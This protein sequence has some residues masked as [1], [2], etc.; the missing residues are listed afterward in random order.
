MEITKRKEF[1]KYL[2]FAVLI[3]VSR[4]PFLVYGYGLDGDSWSVAISAKHLF[5]TG[6]YVPSRLPGYPVHEFLCA[7]A[8]PFGYIG[9]NLVSAIF[10]TIAVTTFALI[11]RSLRFKSIFL[12]ATTFSFV[13]VI[14]IHSTTTI[15]YNIALAFIMLAMFF[16]IR[17]KLFIAGCFVALAIGTRLT[18]GAM[19]LPLSIMLL[20]ND[21]LNNNI[22]RIA[23]MVIPA[24]IGGVLFYIPLMSKYGLGFF[25]YYDVPYPAIPKVLYKLSIEVWGTIG[26]LG[27]FI[28]TI[29][30]FLPHNFSKNKFLFPRSINEKYVIAWLVAVDIYIIAFLKLPMESGYLIPIVPFII[31]IYGK[32]LYNRAFVFFCSMLIISSLICTISPA[33]R[34]DAATVSSMTSTFNAGGE[35]LTLDYLQGPVY[36]Y[37]TRRENGITF[38]NSLLSSM[39]TITIPSVIVSGRWYNQLIVQS[40]DTSKLKAKIRDYISEPEALYFYAKGYLIYYLPKQEYYNKVMRNVDLDVYRAIPYLKEN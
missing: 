12:A 30:F 38:V 14:F 31:L 15:D 8:S 3:F 23:R 2:L 16:M 37:H 33:D 5:S 28:S 7:I 4:L 35:K 10:T 21:G 40:N 6:E 26:I 22:K 11:L 17:D 25:T 20:R 36:S 18:S 19:L 9:M 39:D 1:Y 29:L 27:I 32:Y 13:P 34:Y 24:V